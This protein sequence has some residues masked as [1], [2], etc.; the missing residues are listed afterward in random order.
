MEPREEP[1]NST[2]VIGKLLVCIDR[3]ELLS[4]LILLFH[5]KVLQN[6]VVVVSLLLHL[7]EVIG[8][9]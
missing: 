6:Y 5:Q 7:L 4:L 2:H 8:V 1:S 9:I 3:L